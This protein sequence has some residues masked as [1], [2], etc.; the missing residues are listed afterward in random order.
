MFAVR[1]TRREAAGVAVEGQVEYVSR[2][3]RT[4]GAPG[5][6]GQHL[7]APGWCISG[8]MTY[9]L[10]DLPMFGGLG[11]GR[12]AALPAPDEAS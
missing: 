12:L 4:L 3:A 10:A 2:H 5:A 9:T 8:Y 6:G 11:D 7:R 1:G